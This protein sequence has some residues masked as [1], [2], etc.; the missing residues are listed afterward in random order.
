MQTGAFMQTPGLMQTA[1]PTQ[2]TAPS[3]P[4]LLL[5]AP[6]STA[7]PIV[8]AL[9]HDLR[10]DVETTSSRRSA[11]TSLRRND[12]AGRGEGIWE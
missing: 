1:A 11:L 12:F 6:E 4:S 10:A 8:E 7:Q 3:Q 9:R 2:T 5:I